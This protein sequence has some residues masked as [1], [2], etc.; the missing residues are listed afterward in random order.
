[1]NGTSIELLSLQRLDALVLTVFMERASDSAA[2]SGEL[3]PEEEAIE[4]LL[5]RTVDSEIQS[6]VKRDMRRLSD[7]RVLEVIVGSGAVLGRGFRTMSAAAGSWLVT[8]VALLDDARVKRP[9][10][11]TIVRGLDGAQRRGFAFERIVDLERLL[12]LMIMVSRGFFGR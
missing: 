2:V 10:D 3:L 5:A 1:M 9:V 7:H 4:G 11:S 8:R 6:T 12:L